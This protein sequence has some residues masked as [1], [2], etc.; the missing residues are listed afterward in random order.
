[1][2]ASM[3]A[4]G[5]SQYFFQTSM[6]DAV[7]RFSACG[8]YTRRWPRKG[9]NASSVCQSPRSGQRGMGSARG[10]MSRLQPWP[11]TSSTSPSSRARQYVGSGPAGGMN[12]LMLV[13]PSVQ[14]NPFCLSTRDL[15]YHGVE[16]TAGVRHPWH[17]G[18][19]LSSFPHC[20]RAPAISR[21]LFAFGRDVVS[22]FQSDLSHLTVT[23][24]HR[25]ACSALVPCM[26]STCRRA[27]DERQT[28]RRLTIMTRCS[29]NVCPGKGS[30]VQ[31]QR[32]LH[33]SRI[34]SQTEIVLPLDCSFS[35][36]LVAAHLARLVGTKTRRASGHPRFTDFRKAG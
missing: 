24:P 9:P 22:N 29:W 28:A 33:A 5:R 2:A 1:M 8:S 36:Q 15:C 20:S 16:T 14:L 34:E 31:S 32:G 19:V 35:S 12:T 7:V 21:G 26:R 3:L 13:R 30:I 4:S 23:L 27:W 25:A 11:C 10:S 17:P 6:G 18:I